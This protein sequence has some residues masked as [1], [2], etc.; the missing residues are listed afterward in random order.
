MSYL[1]RIDFLPT[2]FSTDYPLYSLHYHIL[3]YQLAFLST[4]LST[5][6]FSYQ[7]SLPTFLFINYPI[8]RL[9]STNFLSTNCLPYQLFFLLTVRQ[10]SLPTVL[11]TTA[12]LTAYP[13]YQLLSLSNV[14]YQLF[15]LLTFL[16]TNCLPYRLFSLTT[17]FFTTVIPTNFPPYQ[18]SS[19]N[20]PF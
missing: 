5:T 20:C 17:V 10:Y 3:L 4:I 12:L 15:S 6:C 2:V 8:Y 7:F 16:S 13:P 19:T 9:S 11:F 1:S 14:L 18:L